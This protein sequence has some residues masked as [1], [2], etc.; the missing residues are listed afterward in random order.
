MKNSTLIVIIIF[1]LLL[2][3][4]FFY[5]PK[6]DKKSEEG[7]LKTKSPELAGLTNWMN[8]EKIESIESLR[9]KA[10]LVYFWTYSCINCI[11][12]LPYLQDLQD[13]YAD[14][15]LVILGIHAPEFTFEK[16]PKNVADALKKYSITYPVALDN[17]FKTWR[18]FKNRFWPAKYL[19]DKNGFVVYKHF[20]EGKYEETENQVRKALELDN[21]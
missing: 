12:T 13:K 1:F 20:G 8:S 19:V 18:N 9:G 11:R 5:W 17:D 10:V 3:L 15:G 16:K 21:I 14:K 7:F 4:I 6:D 2:I